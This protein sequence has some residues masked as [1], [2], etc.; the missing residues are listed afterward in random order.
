[1][2]QG[3]LSK[4]AYSKTSGI[5]PATFYNW[6]RNETG[7]EK[8]SFVEINKQ[9]LMGKNEEIVIEKDR[10]IIR[11]PFSSGMKELQTVFAALEGQQ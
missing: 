3:G 1:M 9:L 8:Q 4:A 11:L 2:K 5:S 7:K 10:I 6:T